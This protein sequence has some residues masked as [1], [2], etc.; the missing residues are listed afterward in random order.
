MTSIRIGN[1]PCSWGIV[2]FTEETTQPLGYVAVLDEIRETGYAGTELGDWGF[3]PT[4]PPALWHELVR[5]GLSMIGAFVPV[6]LRTP[7]AHES[8]ADDAVRTA[9]LLAAVADADGPEGYPVI[10]LADDCGADPVRT[11]NAGRVTPRMGMTDAEWDGFA[12]GAER[13]AGIVRDATGLRTAFHPHCAGFVETP[14]EIARFLD[15]TDPTLVGLVLDTGHLAY[16]AGVNDPSIVTDALDHFGDRIWHVHLKDCEARVADRARR[17]QIAY[18]EAVGRG[19]F[20]ELGRGL[21]DFP[22]VIGWLRH[23][24]YG[25]WVVVEQDVFP[26]M[27]SPRES[28][29]RNQDYLASIGL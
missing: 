8:G 25:G 29:R 28:A 27:G 1:A 23:R 24:G 13:I 22:A 6:A 4:D 9:R 11:L 14:D 26:G 18:N 7:E 19:V 10:V 15:L 2:E 3:M 21:V 17:D 5:R 12:H 20:C 16:G